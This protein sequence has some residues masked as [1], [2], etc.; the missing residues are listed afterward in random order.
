ME[1]V[2]ERVYKT[3]LE[4]SM[5]MSIKGTSLENLNLFKKIKKQT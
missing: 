2:C 5:T 1:E 4:W 3:F